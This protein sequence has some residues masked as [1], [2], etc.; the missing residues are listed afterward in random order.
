MIKLS[1]NFKLWRDIFSLGA[2]ATI[3]SDLFNISMFG[4]DTYIEPN[5]WILYPEIVVALTSI[6][7]V[8]Y[9]I[10]VTLEEKYK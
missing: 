4:V 5:W 1:N 8:G 6:A 3:L 10:Y 2:I 9:S 7:M